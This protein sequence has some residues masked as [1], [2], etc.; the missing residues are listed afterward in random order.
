[1]AWDPTSVIQ[2]RIDTSIPIIS[3]VEVSVNGKSLVINNVLV[4]T[5]SAGTILSA[6]LMLDIGIKP[7]IE[8]ALI[9][10]LG[11]GGTE[12]AFSKIVDSMKVGHLEVRDFKIQVGAMDYP[13]NVS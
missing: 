9:V 3:S 10:I 2:L 12:Y 13:K 7:K 8:D 6:D 11:V 5:G 1:M 4:D